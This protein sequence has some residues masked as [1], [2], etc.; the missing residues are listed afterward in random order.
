MCPEELV[1][2]MIQ[3]REIECTFNSTEYFIEP[4]FKGNIRDEFKVNL[5][6]CNKGQSSKQIFCGSPLEVLNFEFEG[7]YKLLEHWD[8]FS[9]QYIL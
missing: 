1:F 5:Y 3:G 6:I 2:Y 9:V 8:M 7:K 4:E